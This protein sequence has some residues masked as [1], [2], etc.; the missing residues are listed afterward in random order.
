MLA[1]RLHLSFLSLL[2]LVFL[3]QC[4]FLRQP[5]VRVEPVYGWEP[6]FFGPIDKATE[7]SKIEDLRDTALANGEFEIRIWRPF[8]ID[9]YEGVVL[10]FKNDAWGAFHISADGERQPHTVTSLPEPKS[11]WRSF[12]NRLLELELL[13]LPNVDSEECKSTIDGLGVVVE[14]SYGGTYRTFMYPINDADCG[15]SRNAEAISDFVG[16][17]FH[18]GIAKCTKYQW[19]ACAS[20]NRN[21][22]LEAEQLR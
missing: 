12:W 6:I 18:D 8:S 17:E 5:P 7:L 11:G 9:E 19:F 16:M 1:R 21:R 3:T 20:I 22:R 13:S 2:I 10:A 4:S 15:G 14:S